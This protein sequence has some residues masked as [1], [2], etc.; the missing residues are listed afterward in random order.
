MTRPSWNPS[1]IDCDKATEMASRGLTL[2][3]TSITEKTDTHCEI[4]P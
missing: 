3:K 1:A 2:A 4:N